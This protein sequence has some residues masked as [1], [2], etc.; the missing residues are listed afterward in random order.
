VSTP[1]S[2]PPTE[3][4]AASTISARS[5]ASVGRVWTVEKTDHIV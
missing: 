3:A 4:R 1:E 5:A 2:A